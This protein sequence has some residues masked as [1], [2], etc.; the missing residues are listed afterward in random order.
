MALTCSHHEQWVLQV[1]KCF[2]GQAQSLSGEWGHY[3]PY[4][5]GSQKRQIDPKLLCQLVALMGTSVWCS[6]FSFP[7]CFMRLSRY[8]PPRT[9]HKQ[10]LTSI[11]PQK[12]IFSRQDF[13]YTKITQETSPMSSSPLVF[14]L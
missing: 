1:G 8:L 12:E 5:E 11:G 2:L 9:L 4:N 7:C 14:E 3:M 6:N 10:F 13:S